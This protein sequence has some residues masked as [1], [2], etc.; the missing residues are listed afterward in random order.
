MC[1]WEFLEHQCVTSFSLRKP[2]LKQKQ[3][4]SMLEIQIST[5]VKEKNPK[6][7][8]FVPWPTKTTQLGSRGGGDSG[9]AKVK[10]IFEFGCQR[11]TTE[12]P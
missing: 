12:T 10:N 3:M 6:S 11:K 7:T 4:D 9:A 5:L 8:D 1:L 2:C